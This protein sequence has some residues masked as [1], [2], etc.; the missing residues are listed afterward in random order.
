MRRLSLLVVLVVAPAVFGDDAVPI[1]GR[2]VQSLRA[3]DE[4]ITRFML[5]NDIGAANVAIS[6]RDKCVYHRAFGWSDEARTTPLTTRVVM[7]LASVSKPFTAAAVRRL[8]RE[9]KLSLSDRVFDLGGSQGLLKLEPH[10]DPDPRL[11]EITIEHLLKHQGGWD[12]NAKGAEDLS[13]REETIAKAFN[14]PSPPGRLLTARWIMG[15]PLQFAPGE[16]EAYANFGYLLLGLV[17]EEVSGEDLVSYLNRYV[18]PKR[19]GW[20]PVKLQLGRTFKEDQDPNE[21]YYQSKRRDRN[22]FYPAASDKA[23]VASPYGAW[24]HEMR[25]ANGALVASAVT[26][27][28]FL[29]RYQVNGDN[30]GGPRP[31]PGNWRWNHTGSLEGTSTLAR[32][33]GDGINYAVLLN[34]RRSGGKDYSLEMREQLD[35]VL[36]RIA[37]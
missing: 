12:R 2:P 35:G 17:V 18:M 33:R 5:E 30:I 32:Q 16:R 1:A 28:D 22:V 23:L 14:V 25:V 7:R 13:Y 27:V 4:T 31:V 20:P 3:V 37:H 8:V 6:Y 29:E 11:S 21:P 10:G 19:R 36:D 26:V 34:K 15:K 9:G 24:D